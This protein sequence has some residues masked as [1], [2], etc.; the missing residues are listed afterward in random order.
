MG[1]ALLQGGD[2]IT[3]PAGHIDFIYL[4]VPGSVVVPP[5][6]LRSFMEVKDLYFGTAD[7]RAREFA[8]RYAIFGD[9]GNIPSDPAPGVSVETFFSDKQS[10][11]GND[12]LIGLEG[13]RSHPPF[14]AGFLHYQVLAHE[15]RH[16]LGLRHGGIDGV[17]TLPP[18]DPGHN[19]AKYKPDYLSLMNYSLLRGLPGKVAASTPTSV[20][21]MAPTTYSGINGLANFTGLDVLNEEAANP[22]SGDRRTI[23]M[24]TF[25]QLVVTS[26]WTTN[27]AINDTVNVLKENYS[28]GGDPV[29]NDWA[30]IELGF[31]S[32]LDSIGTSYEENN[33]GALAENQRE[34]GPTVD[35]WESIHGPLDKQLPMITIVTPTSGSGVG[36]SGQSF[37]VSSSVT[38]DSGVAG[39]KVRFDTDGDGTVGAA[40][41]Y[42]ATLQ[43]NTRWEAQVGPLAGSDGSRTVTVEA[44]DVSGIDNE[45]TV[46]VMVP[47]PGRLLMLLSGASLVTLLERTRRGKHARR[48]GA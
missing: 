3:D 19:P 11:P 48:S 2:A 45:A 12:L 41:E 26:M 39:V 38:D 18:I 37:L 6:V 33:R 43:P 10:N 25:N 32:S 13:D 36:T 21:V 24:N 35:D 46:P 42:T 47:E 27:P 28:G 20:M 4:G 40:E 31:A 9:K 34:R 5:F 8:F 7:K 30:A 17:T 14:P 22:G 29:F 23:S 15:L 44:I 16:T 1:T